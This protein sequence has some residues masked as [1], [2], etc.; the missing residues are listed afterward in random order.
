MDIPKKTEE[1][2]LKIAYPSGQSKDKHKL[3]PCDIVPD[4][5]QEL[6]V[7]LMNLFHIHYSRENK[8]PEGVS[9]FDKETGNTE[10]KIFEIELSR[11]E[12]SM[13]SKSYYLNKYDEKLNDKLLD[14][15]DRIY[16]LEVDNK[17]IYSSNV[18]LILLRHL[19]QI[20]ES[21]YMTNFRVHC[22][23]KNNK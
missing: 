11:F 6:H 23:E 16:H 5:E 17:K 12:Q 9:M 7:E 20:K 10:L 8:L 1:A 2:I 4:K 22:S 21:D 13:F 3:R 19:V 14:K 15:Y 18:L